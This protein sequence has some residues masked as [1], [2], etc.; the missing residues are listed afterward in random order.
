M[1]NWNNGQETLPNPEYSW[2]YDYIAVVNGHS[3]K[4]NCDFENEICEVIFVD[5]EWKL[6]LDVNAEIEVVK[7]M[8]LESLNRDSWLDGKPDEWVKTRTALGTIYENDEGNGFNID[9]TSQKDKELFMA[10][11]RQV[12]GEIKSGN[13]PEINKGDS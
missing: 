9:F 2:M 10:Y 1:N 5:F 4:L 8:A 11:Q 3:D 6:S 7:W 13:I 12:L